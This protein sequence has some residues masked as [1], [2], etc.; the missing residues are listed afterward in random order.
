MVITTRRGTQST[1]QSKTETHTPVYRKKKQCGKNSLGRC[2]TLWGDLD[3]YTHLT[4]IHV[5]I[6]TKT[7]TQRPTQTDTHTLDIWGGVDICTLDGMSVLLSVF[8]LGS[9]NKIPSRLNPIYLMFGGLQV[10]K[11]HVNAI[12]THVIHPNPCPE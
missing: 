9:L 3:V 12:L 2:S 11:L 5:Y 7:V 1:T 8:R 10:K 4:H 6:Y